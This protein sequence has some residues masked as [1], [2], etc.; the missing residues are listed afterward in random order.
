MIT[1]G[2]LMSAG[3]THTPKPGSHSVAVKLPYWEYQSLGFTNFPPPSNKS[4]L[5]RYPEVKK[6]KQEGWTLL[7]WGFVGYPGE[8]EPLFVA[9]FRRPSRFSH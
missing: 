4:E 7:N 5:N 3:C 2:V 6:M 8:A 1:I 9:D